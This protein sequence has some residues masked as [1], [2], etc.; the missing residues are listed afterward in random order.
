MIWFITTINKIFQKKNQT[1]YENFVNKYK[2]KNSKLRRKW[3]SMVRYP[4]HA[5]YSFINFRTVFTNNINFNN[6]NFLVFFSDGNQ[7]FRL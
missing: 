3:R 4:Q 6:F 1:S 2:Q 5:N 7:F